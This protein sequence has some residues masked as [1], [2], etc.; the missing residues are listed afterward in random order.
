MGAGRGDEALRRLRAM[1]RGG[2]PLLPLLSVLWRVQRADG[3]AAVQ[4]RRAAACSTSV[5]VPATAQYVRLCRLLRV[6][7]HP[8][9]SALCPDSGQCA[10]NGTTRVRLA[11]HTP[12]QRQLWHGVSLS[13]SRRGAMLGGDIHLSWKHWQSWH[14][15]FSSEG[16]SVMHWAALD[17]GVQRNCVPT[18]WRS[19]PECG[20]QLGCRARAAYVATSWAHGFRLDAH[21]GRYTR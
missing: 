8:C 12:G 3:V 2:A 7:D 15:R 10:G 11:C 18:Q 14:R 9:L 1:L 17:V 21:A 16:R 6:V 20:V 5:A 19:K 13:N 4:Y